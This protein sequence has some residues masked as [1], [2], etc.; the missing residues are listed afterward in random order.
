MRLTKNN[1]TYNKFLEAC[2]DI[3]KNTKKSLKLITLLFRP[4][5]NKQIFDIFERYRYHINSSEFGDVV[6]LS[7]TR[8]IYGKE[9]KVYYYLLSHPKYEEIYYMFSFN[10]SGDI[11]N[12]L[13]R[14]VDSVPDL[15]YLWLP[16]SYF[17]SL[18]EYILNKEGSY[19]TYFHG[20]KLEESGRQECKKRPLF[21]RD[22]KYEGEDAELSSEEIRFEYGVLPQSI[23]FV[24]PTVSRFRVHK[25]GIYTLFFGNIEEFLR[26]VVEYAIDLVIRDNKEIEKAKFDVIQKGEIE[27]LNSEEIRF[28]LQNE[29]NYE[30]FQG[31]IETMDKSDF[32]AYNVRLTEGSIIFSGNIVDE[33]KGNIFS[34]TSDGKNFTIIP[35]HDSS[36]ISIIRFHRFLIE[37]IDQQTQVVYN[38]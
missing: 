1:Y 16:P 33:L 17:D 2:Q 34:V 20:K 23:E 3:K 25:N 18:K 30:E 14:V 12:T 37:K 6:E 22:I 19:I 36:F 24:V 26:S 15:Y 7:T 35:K 29:I 4:H 38:Q 11:Y 31:F 28:S 27:I 21:A 10:S 32:S 5:D 9:K 13:P 8:R